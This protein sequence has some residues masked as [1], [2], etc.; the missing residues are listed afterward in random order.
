MEIPEYKDFLPEEKDPKKW[1]ATEV[2]TAMVGAISTTLVITQELRE[3]LNRIEEM[4]L[5]LP[6]HN[7]VGCSWGYPEDPADVC[8]DIKDIERRTRQLEDLK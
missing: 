6:T 7:D 8:R 3:R 5:K 2:S 4:I 1:T